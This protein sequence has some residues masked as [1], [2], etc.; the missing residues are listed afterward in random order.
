MEALKPR[1]VRKLR[2]PGFRHLF[3]AG[4]IV[5]GLLMLKILRFSYTP[6]NAG[7]VDPRSAVLVR[8]RL[9]RDAGHFDWFPAQ[10]QKERIMRNPQHLAK[11]W[12]GRK[13]GESLSRQPC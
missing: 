8:A 5:L 4:E 2:H 1:S 7:L 6:A 9:T 12:V 13:L 3:G 10:V 11:G